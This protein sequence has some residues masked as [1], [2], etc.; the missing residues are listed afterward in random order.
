MQF[1]HPH[2]RYPKTPLLTSGV[3]WYGCLERHPGTQTIFFG[4]VQ[5]NQHHPRYPKTPLLAYEVQWYGCLERHPRTQTMFF[6][7]VQSNHP[8]PRDPKTPLLAYGVQWHGCFERH[9]RTQTNFLASCS[10]NSTILGIQKQLCWSM[11]Y[12]GTGVWSASPERKQIFWH[13]AIQT[14]PS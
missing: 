2:P 5:F 13:R 14:S 9:P 7:I 10:S 11:E 6:G 1:K 3:Q 4:I 8:Q 12:S